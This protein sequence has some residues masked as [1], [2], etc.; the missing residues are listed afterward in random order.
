MFNN[1]D[2]EM[3]EKILFVLVITVPTLFLLLLF[4]SDRYQ[5]K[6][7]QQ[8][9][10][11]KNS[12]RIADVQ[13]ARRNKDNSD[14]TTNAFVYDT[15]NQNSSNH[16]NNDDDTFKGGGGS[17]GGGGASFSWGSSSSSDSSSSSSDS[18]SSSY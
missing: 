16:L 17:S 5:Q 9:L 7:K 13:R 11:R 6:I 1:E 10:K 8:N 14:L 4:I 15:L 12:Q 18:S 2:F 3:I